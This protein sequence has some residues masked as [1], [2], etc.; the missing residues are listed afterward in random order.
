MLWPA[1][2][3]LGAQAA[4]TPAVIRNVDEIL[5]SDD[6]A[7]R[8]DGT[9]K[10]GLTV[11]EVLVDPAGKPQTCGVA[12]ASGSKER[13]LRACAEAVLR[14]KYTPAAD[15]HRLPVFGILRLRVL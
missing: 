13:D 7:T 1:M 10:R 9:A 6:Y 2:L 14:G 8:A 5:T 15:E 4:L 12:S 11:I 3:V